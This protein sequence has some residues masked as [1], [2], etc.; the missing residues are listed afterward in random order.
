M[1]SPDAEAVPDEKAVLNEAE[2]VGD[3]KQVVDGK[4]LE[5]LGS[6]PSED[7]NDPLTW[8]LPLKVCLTTGEPEQS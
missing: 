2:P 4:G 3:N 5:G 1:A 7:P 8:S 6:R